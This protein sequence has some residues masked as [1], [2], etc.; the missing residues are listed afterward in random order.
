MTSFITEQLD[1]EEK[2]AK[3]CPQDV[4]RYFSCAI[5]LHVFFNHLG[6]EF[7]CVTDLENNTHHLFIYKYRKNGYSIRF[8]YHLPSHEII[9]HVKKEFKVPYVSLNY[10]KSE[11]PEL[12]GRRMISEREMIRDV[13][14]V[15]HLD[16]PKIKKEYAR[17]VKENSFYFEEWK[18]N[19]AQEVFDFLA[20]WKTVRTEK[21]NQFAL[22]ENDRRFVELYASDKRIYGGVA[23]DMETHAVIGITFG[24][25]DHG[26]KGI[27][28][29]NKCL[30]GYTNLGT[31]LVVENARLAKKR[32]IEKL[33]VGHIN[34][35]FKLKFK[36]GATIFNDWS[37]ELVCEL[38]PEPKEN[39]IGAVL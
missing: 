3:Y 24:C 28:L 15:A 14:T 6:K 5:V 7:Y 21:Q 33:Y 10:T 29:F 32:G 38:D 16:D 26:I 36:R 31:F 19:F 2:I 30:R 13:K 34:N 20:V 8:L 11:Y 12:V 9:D 18:P 17:T 4:E 1:T 39:Y 22:T 35:E 25:A 23:R 27:G 37:Y